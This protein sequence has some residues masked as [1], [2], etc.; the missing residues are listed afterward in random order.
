[1]E[2][3]HPDLARP[4]APRRLKIYV[5][6][7]S[8]VGFVFAFMTI[9]EGTGLVAP[10]RAVDVAANLIFGTP[11]F[12]LPFILLWKAPGEKRSRLALCAE[13]ILVYIPLTAG[14]QLTYELPFLLGHPF[15]LWRTTSDPGWRW[16]WWQYGLADTR[17]RSDNMFIFGLEFG[18]VLVGILLFV[19]WM[20]MLRR[21]LPDES[22]IRRLW[23]SF[24]SIA[25]LDAGTTIY[26]VAEIRAG[27]ADIGQGAYGLWFK[28]IG[29]NVPYL[30]LPYFVLYA[31][32][33]LTDHLTRLAGPV[34]A[35]AAAPSESPSQD[36]VRAERTTR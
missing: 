20:K 23:M 17:Y 10:S 36:V 2:H 25:V 9:A 19:L 11:V 33:Y 14:S 6:L 29:E 7:F 24:F 22:R 34:A 4:F 15:N 27:F 28:F 31:I 8:F 32:Y 3:T 5:V 18:A 16:L 35:P 21:D 12:V 13:L 1:M 30:I 26:Y